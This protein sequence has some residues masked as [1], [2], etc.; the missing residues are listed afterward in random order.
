MKTHVARWTAVAVALLWGSQ[1]WM[2]PAAAADDVPVR[3]PGQ[4]EL[5]TISAATGTMVSRVCITPEDNIIVS[6]SRGTCTTPKVLRAGDQTI[7]D[8]VCKTAEGEERIS[9]LLT[10]DFTDWYRAIVKM[11]FDP[12]GGGPPSL[13]VTIEGR[14]LGEECP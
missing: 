12:P 7:V 5:K 4:W 14:F 10:G 3:R 2:G 1:V 9:T 6:P 8:T 13:G 11:T